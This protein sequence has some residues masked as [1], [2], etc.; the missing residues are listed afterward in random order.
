[1]TCGHAL[2]AELLDRMAFERRA[3]FQSKYRGLTSGRASN[4]GQTQ[5]PNG[6]PP[7]ILSP[8]MQREALAMDHKIAVLRR[9]MQ[10]V[11]RIEAELRNVTR[12]ILAK[13]R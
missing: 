5:S 1:M 8:L 3:V 4:T 2:C 7:L 10:A 11:H 12:R 6:N 9:D 13:G